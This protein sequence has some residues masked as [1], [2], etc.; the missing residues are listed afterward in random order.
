MQ[1]YDRPVHTASPSSVAVVPTSVLP[2]RFRSI[3][4]FPAFNP[5]QSTCFSTIYSTDANV[6]IAAPTGSGKTALFELA[7]L[8]TLVAPMAAGALRG[9]DAKILY[10]APTK[11]LCLERS[12]DWAARLAI[13]GLK[14]GML[15]G[16][17]ATEEVET[18]KSSNIIIT[19]PEKW[20]ATTRK[21]NDYDR[22]MSLVKLIM[23]DEV[24]ILKDTRGATLE[25][26]VSRMKHIAPHARFVAL[27]A[28]IP[29]AEDI[30][31]WLGA[32]GSARHE[33]TKLHLFGS[34][35]RPVP[36]EIHVHGF[37]S[38]SQ[39]VFQLDKLYDSKLN[40]ILDTYYAQKPIIIFCPTRKITL[41]TAKSLVK[42]WFPSRRVY[43]SPNV[44]RTLGFNDPELEAVARI[45]VA[46]HH[47][48]LSLNDRTLVERMFCDHQIL[49]I[50]STST[51]AV[52]LPAQLVIIK[53][54]ASWI[55]G[56]V[57]E[58]TEFDMQQMMG[59]AGRPQFDTTGT[60]VIMTTKDS[61]ENYAEFDRREIVESSLHTSL[62][63]HINA[64]IC[65]GTVVDIA[66]AMNWLRSTF[67]YVRL[68]KNLKY[69]N[70]GSTYISHNVDS[71]LERLVT[72]NFDMLVSSGI[73][74][75]E[76]INGK[77][78]LAA[79]PR[80][81]SMALFYVRYETMK[82]FCRARVG[83]QLQDV[84]S[85]L[86]RADEFN[87]IRFK[88]G[89]K[90][91]YKEINCTPNLRFPFKSSDFSEY[92]DKVSLIIQVTLG[93]I[94][95]PVYDGSSKHAST[96]QLDKV[97]I[98]QHVHR[99]AS[100]LL[101]CT[102]Q[103]NDSVST[104]NVLEL[105]RSLHAEIWDSSSSVL[106]QL[107]GVGPAS[108]R[109]FQA[110][111]IQTF[112]DVR[113]MDSIRVETVLKLGRGRGIKLLQEIEKIPKFAVSLKKV[114]ET[115]DTSA[116]HVRVGVRVVVDMVNKTIVRMHRRKMI[117]V[118]FLLEM[119]SG[120]IVDYRRAM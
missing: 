35:F 4:R 50:C 53:G 32:N 1:F 18:V 60:A 110:H 7:M 116:G 59:R 109:K 114:S 86:C 39:N 70:L 105:A 80:S 85:L 111:N 30:A 73:V 95:L 25:V 3:F 20:D 17:T 12:R 11:A 43:S 106:L 69:Y 27:S 47:A 112:D 15:T 48:G 52:N 21:W 55:E 74:T 72:E 46:Y 36:L 107:D 101:D 14:C 67:L 61:E 58:Y 76:L 23:I 10:I 37:P 96:F 88:P 104:R 66:S 102:M 38:K 33:P 92:S 13:L 24:H 119:T 75:T 99:L 2:D 29:N 45:G 83:M 65:L 26:I 56:S 22:L 64:E 98:W 117:T 63:E 8:R 97:L 78:K 57:Q 34:E 87:G 71:I 51:L 118:T 100:C 49:I 108:L 103:T 40:D 41:T 91:F 81:K 89:E 90:K 16:D 9:G 82:W 68:K 120:K 62:V 5:M 44:G 54:T 6:V 77:Q 115:K 42:S 113:D 84:L 28:T 79:T 94:E 19:T 31:E 93:Q